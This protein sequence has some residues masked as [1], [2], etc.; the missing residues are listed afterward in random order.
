MHAIIEDNEPFIL[1]MN[2][3]DQ[4]YEQGINRTGVKIESYMPYSPI[5]IEI[6]QGK[7]QPT[8]RVTLRDE[9]DFEASFYLIVN[10]EQFEITASDIKTEDLVYKYGEE[11]FGLTEENLSE[12]IW[13]YIYPALVLKLKDILNGKNSA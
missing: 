1:D 6:K 13:Q 2:S 10:D 9:G 3:E 5:T 4:L 11:I 7:G 8:N 12:L